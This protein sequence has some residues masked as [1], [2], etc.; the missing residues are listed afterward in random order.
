MTKVAQNTKLKVSKKFVKDA[1]SRYFTK[2]KPNK[3]S[4]IIIIITFFWIKQT[5]IKTVWQAKY[6]K[7][8]C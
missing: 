1:N 6:I 2:L 8:S 7:K 5:F 4:I 3:K